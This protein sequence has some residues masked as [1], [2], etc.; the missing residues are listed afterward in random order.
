MTKEETRNLVHNII[1]FS[2]DE[3]GRVL[4]AS[5][6]Q[7]WSERNN[8]DIVTNDQART[9]LEELSKVV[10]EAAFTVLSRS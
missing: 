1:N 5:M 8:T 4:A 6:T 9:L 10:R 2:N 3:I 7:E